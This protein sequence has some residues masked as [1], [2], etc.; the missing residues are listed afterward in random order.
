MLGK[1]EKWRFKSKGRK[2]AVPS[3]L[4]P[5]AVG[6]AGHPAT[7]N[8]YVPTVRRRIPLNLSKNFPPGKDER[9]HPVRIGQSLPRNFEIQ[10]VSRYAPEPFSM[11]FSAN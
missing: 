9:L 4:L 11:Q 10:K 8:V 3:F 1:Q 6:Y 5:T 2:T 7:Q